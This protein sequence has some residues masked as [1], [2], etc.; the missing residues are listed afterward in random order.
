MLHNIPKKEDANNEERMSSFLGANTK[1]DVFSALPR[2]LII[3]VLAVLLLEFRPGSPI[4]GDTALH[5]NMSLVLPY[6]VVGLYH[7][8]HHHAG[9]LNISGDVYVCERNVTYQNQAS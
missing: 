5:P 1:F 6:T 3:L 7:G 4:P 9:H 8:A 2:T